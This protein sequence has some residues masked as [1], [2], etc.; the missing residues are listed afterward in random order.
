[1]SSDEKINKMNNNNNKTNSSKTTPNRTTI[2]RSITSVASS[3]AIATLI[4]AF[5]GLLT[6]L[7][8]ALALVVTGDNDNNLNLIGTGE[9][10]VIFGLGGNDRIFGLAGPDEL[11]GERDNPYDPNI[12]CEGGYQICD[13]T[14]YGADGADAIYGGPGI[15]DLD[16]GNHDDYL[17]DK[18]NRGE[19]CNVRDQKTG[20]P[21]YEHFK[22]GP[23]QDW[24]LAGDLQFLAPGEIRSR[25]EGNEGHDTIIG[26]NCNDLIYGDLYGAAENTAAIGDGD[27]VLIGSWGADIVTGTGGNDRLEGDS[28]FDP[29]CQPTECGTDYLSGGQGHDLISGHGNGFASQDEILKGGPG[30]DRLI[31]DDPRCDGR[32]CGGPDRLEGGEGDD[33]MTGGFGRDTFVCG[34][35]TDTITD[36]NTITD[37]IED[38]DPKN[39]ENI[40]RV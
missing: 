36:F 29:F 9:A 14:I 26:S 39:C 16:G 40:E 5:P 4:I 6:Q 13:D 25:M 3:L 19:D 32:A 1:M 35:G 23:G 37:I 18:A 28:P 17:G 22:G 24:L 31:G 21:R 30:N 27:D 10:D 2:R 38:A 33:T 8:P 12:R 7:P 15:D 11:F 34:P 20:I